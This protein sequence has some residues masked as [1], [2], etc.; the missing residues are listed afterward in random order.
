[1]TRKRYIKLL[2]ALG[3]QRNYADA[4]AY[5][6]QVAGRS[7][8]ADYKMRSP[9]L[10]LALFSRRVLRNATAAVMHLA[11]SITNA[12]AA[13]NLQLHHP[14]PYTPENVGDGLHHNMQIV[15]QAEHA[16]IHGR[17]DGYNAG[18]VMLDELD[19]QGGGGND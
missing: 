5:A 16:A 4:M 2:M 7:Y 18:T 13:T 8:A 17:L 10:R 15:T 14:T 19:A 11:E 12:M 9:W 1:M 6:C 3:I